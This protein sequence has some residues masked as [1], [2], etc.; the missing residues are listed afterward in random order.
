[1]PQ[2]ATPVLRI[3]SIAAHYGPIR[4]LEDVVRG[5]P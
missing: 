5:K 1:M 2:D 3:E 4:A